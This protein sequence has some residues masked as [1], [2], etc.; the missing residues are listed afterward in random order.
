MISVQTTM[1]SLPAEILAEISRDLDG[2]S[3]LKFAATCIGIYASIRPSC[4]QKWHLCAHKWR[5]SVTLEFIN[6]RKVIICNI[7]SAKTDRLEN[8]NISLHYMFGK[9]VIYY[10]TEQS[11]VICTSPRQT[12]ILGLT[13]ILSYKM[14][15]KINWELVYHI[16]I[17]RSYLDTQWY[18]DEVHYNKV[19]LPLLNRLCIYSYKV[20]HHQHI[21]VMQLYI[22][23]ES[24]ANVQD[25]N[26]N[27]Y[28]DQLNLN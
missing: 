21:Q 4:A 18:N 23:G 28:K 24:C 27:I 19:I 9:Q 6:I 20:L 7:T 5:F 3:T 8:C 17:L 11:H 10:R 26:V 22:N 16:N 25:R 13:S 12:K 15:D 1:E 14:F 2:P